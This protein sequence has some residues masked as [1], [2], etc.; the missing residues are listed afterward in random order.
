MTQSIARLSSSFLGRPPSIQHSHH[1]TMVDSKT[2]AALRKQL[3]I[4]ASVVKRWVFYLFTNTS[5]HQ[6]IQSLS[7]SLVIESHALLFIFSH[8]PLPPSDSVT[9]GIH[10]FLG[11][12]IV[13]NPIFYLHIYSL[14]TKKKKTTHTHRLGKEQKLYTQENQ[15][16]KLKLDKSITSGT[17]G[18]EVNNGVRFSHRNHSFFS[19]FLSFFSFPK[20]SGVWFMRTHALWCETETVGRRIR[21][22]DCRY[23][24]P[25]GNCSSRA[26]RSHRESSLYLLP[27]S[28]HLGIFF[29][30]SSKR[31]NPRLT[32]S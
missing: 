26:Q 17:D 32:R 25:V 24:S 23:E 13:R 5:S 3:K 15:D 4:K 14:V 6:S 16:L 9:G 29:R 21:E 20:P 1:Q 19:F 12:G 18:W 8:S 30:S 11:C 22:D 27:Y 10:S 31:F 7:L 28:F 2:T